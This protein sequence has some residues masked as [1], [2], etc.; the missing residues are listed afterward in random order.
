MLPSTLAE[1]RDGSAVDGRR[2][3]L[4][5]GVVAGLLVPAYFL[6]V[7]ETSHLAWDFRA[8]Y[9][10]ASAA[11]VGDGFVGVG[12]VNPGVSY[13]YPPIAV[14]LFLPQAAVG[15]LW[16]GYLLQTAVGS[17]AAVGVGLLVVSTVERR[18]SLST[19]DRVLVV[20]FCLGSA[21]TAAA[22]GLGQVDTLVALALAGAFVAV[23][24]DHEVVAGVA[25]A[26][27]A[28]VKVFPAVLGL[29]LV[30]RRAWRGVGAAVA[31]GVA[32]LVAG[33]LWFGLDAYRR[34][35]T[36]LAGRSRVADFAAGV[37]PDF[38]AMTLYRPLSHALPG[39]DPAVYGPVA[40]LVLAGPVWLV[41][42]SETTL[43]DRLRTYLV[44]VVAV[45]LVSPASNS[46]YVVYVFFPLLCLAYLDPSLAPGA[47]ESRAGPSG[48]DPEPARRGGGRLGRA[49][50]VLGLVAVAVP[51]QPAQVGGALSA[52]GAPE[53]ATA[54]VLGVL[55][56]ALSVVS[57]PLVGLVAV[58][59]WCVLRAGRRRRT[60]PSRA[61]VNAD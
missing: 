21:P 3:A 28:L 49:L 54:A 11:L 25:L 24:R 26:G 14:V 19:V 40:A 57:V 23:E 53:P 35:L 12:T 29:W 61:P 15:D 33:A 44:G 31:T 32:G 46:V 30:R 45:L 9:A 42:T 7:A 10:A 5:V 51:V 47:S 41:A 1:R 13:V 60:T 34:Y 59:C 50:F 2:G 55:R 56:P 39:V 52:L 36:V 17:A 20:G 8:Y 48:H 4:L 22:L 43:T 6:G 58:L 18:R 37:S 27:A 38:F 16:A